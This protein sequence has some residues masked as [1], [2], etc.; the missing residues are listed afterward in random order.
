ME[1]VCKQ[2]VHI[3][4]ITQQYESKY[5]DQNCVLAIAKVSFRFCAV[6]FKIFAIST[7]QPLQL[8]AYA[9]FSSLILLQKQYFQFLCRKKF[10]QDQ[11][12]LLALINFVSL[13][14]QQNHPKE[15]SNISVRIF[16]IQL[17]EVDQLSRIFLL[18]LILLLLLQQLIQ[19]FLLILHLLGTFKKLWNKFCIILFTN[20]VNKLVLNKEI[21]DFD[22]NSKELDFLRKIIVYK[23]QAKVKKSDPKKLLLFSFLFF[24]LVY[25]NNNNIYIQQQ[26]GF[27]NQFMFRKHNNCQLIMLIT[28]YIRNFI[29]G[30]CDHNKGFVKC[31]SINNMQLLN[32]LQGNFV[33]RYCDHNK[34]FVKCKSIYIQLLLLLLLL[35][36]LVK[37]QLF[38]F[39]KVFL[40][41]FKFYRLFFNPQKLQSIIIIVIH[42]FWSVDQ[43]CILF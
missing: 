25:S 31:K 28:I 39:I 37:R 30:Y 7:V 9:I 10:V 17:T 29:I 24:F 26:L 4:W 15:R 18:I 43:T 41:M 6:I 13:E 19:Q 1:V 11:V 8:F 22:I 40:V 38:Y 5:C 34:G 35:N 2:F 42:D 3:Y 32:N 27:K 21:F 12:L 20:S 23:Q 16:K 33:I 14:T 36:K